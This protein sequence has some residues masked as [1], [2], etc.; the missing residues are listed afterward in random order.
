MGGV[1]LVDELLALEEIVPI[2]RERIARV[3]AY[4]LEIIRLLHY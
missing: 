2:E 1:V 3:R 4:F